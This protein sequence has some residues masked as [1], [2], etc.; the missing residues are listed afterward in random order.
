MGQTAGPGAAESIQSLET[1]KT[2]VRHEIPYEPPVLRM[3]AEVSYANTLHAVASVRDGS[4]SHAAWSQAR[5]NEAMAAALLSACKASQ[6]CPLSTKLQDIVNP[7]TEAIKLSESD[8][9]AAVKILSQKD[10]SGAFRIQKAIAKLDRSNFPEDFRPLL[11]KYYLT[12]LFVLAER[13]ASSKDISRMLRRPQHGGALDWIKLHISNGPVNRRGFYRVLLKLR[14]HLD[15]QSINVLLQLVGRLGNEGSQSRPISKAIQKQSA[16][17]ARFESL[18]MA[19][20]S[21][22]LDQVLNIATETENAIKSKAAAMTVK[23]RQMSE[24]AL[25]R[26]L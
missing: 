10:A 3:P 7:I 12:A 8:V 20:E 24:A 23:L 11:G 13:G 4:D 22:D 2:G 15:E 21:Y 18:S 16:Q 19:Q 1:V 26:R 17:D 6:L 5:Y 25:E 9:P 14:Q